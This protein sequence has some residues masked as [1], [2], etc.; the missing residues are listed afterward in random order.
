MKKNV[1]VLTF[2]NWTVL[3]KAAF[4]AFPQIWWRIVTI[5]ISALLMILVGTVIAAGMGLLLFGDISAVESI[6]A[7]LTSTQ[8]LTLAQWGILGLILFFWINWA[9]VFGITAKIANLLVLKDY[10]H[11]RTSNPFTLFFQTAWSFFW[12]CIGLGF[13]AFWYV[14]WPILVVGILATIVLKVSFADVYEPEVVLEESGTSM[15]EMMATKPMPPEV[16]RMLQDQKGIDLEG[17][18]PLAIRQE[19]YYGAEDDIPPAIQFILDKM[20]AVIG[21]LLVL[22]LFFMFII[23]RSTN[24]VFAQ[25][26]L[27]EH[28]ASAKEAFDTSLALVKGNW[29]AVVFSVVGFFMA[30]SV[31]PSMAFGII[32]VTFVTLDLPALIIDILSNIYSWLVVAPLGVAFM[33]FVML[34]LMKQKKIS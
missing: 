27:I 7:N 23:W 33:Y 26:H 22:F 12:R 9:I 21:G 11:K 10:V 15:Q 28:G 2:D 17:A 13:R 24:V 29:W 25:M 19:P 14:Y 30:V 18:D 1:D 6:V 3:F 4:K 5:N 34:H 31:L 8:N 32:S 16:E 20:G